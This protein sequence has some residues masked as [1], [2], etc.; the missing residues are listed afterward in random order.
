[1]AT[2]K[3][4]L[5][6]NGIRRPVLDVC[7]VPPPPSRG[8]CDREGVDLLPAPLPSSIRTVNA[9]DEDVGTNDTPPGPAPRPSGV[10]ASFSRDCEYSENNASCAAKTS[11]AATA[12]K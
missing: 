8:E 12:R 9:D 2:S 11:P 4:R 1:M 3:R 10:S 6:N 7:G 5:S